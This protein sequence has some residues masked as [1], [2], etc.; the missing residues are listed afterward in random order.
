[1]GEVLKFEDYEKQRKS[2]TPL[3]VNIV[4]GTRCALKALGLNI[5]LPDNLEHQ[6]A[7]NKID[8]A[9][10]D[11]LRTLDDFQRFILQLEICKAV[12]DTHRLEN[13]DIT[14][15]TSPEKLLPLLMLDQ[16]TYIR[17][18]LQLEANEFSQRCRFDNWPTYWRYFSNDYLFERDLLD[19]Q[20]LKC[21]I[22]N[23]VA[24]EFTVCAPM[25]ALTLN[26]DDSLANS[27]AEKVA[28]FHPD[29]F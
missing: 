14:M 16:A 24:D 3:E 7:N 11:Q 15:I 27:L 25:V 23:F 29:L 18:L 13:A 10:V 12:H 4:L 2:Q 26:E 28:K 8:P 5:E 20:S 22:Q 6:I 21:Y 9:F 17:L 19:Y 1:M